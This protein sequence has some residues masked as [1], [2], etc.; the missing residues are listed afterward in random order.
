M[1]DRSV[2]PEGFV[3][4]CGAPCVW[5]PH[6][7][8]VTQGGLT[9]RGWWE[10]SKKCGHAYLSRASRECESASWKLS[11][12]KGSVETG[13]FRIRAEGKGAGKADLL[14]RIA[15]LPDIEAELRGVLRDVLTPATTGH[16]FSG[17]G[18]DRCE[19]SPC[20]Y[21]RAI[22]ELLPQQSDTQEPA[23]PGEQ[24]H[25]DAQV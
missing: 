9:V 10:C 13:N 24:D 22:E 14:E 7:V 2:E 12:V 5:N 23:E 18:E 19:C 17:Q 20:A 11:T 4:E 21:R 3:C 6:K 1:K 8:G 16:N 25:G 15:R